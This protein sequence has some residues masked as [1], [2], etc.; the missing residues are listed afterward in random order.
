[1]TL[2]PQDAPDNASFAISLIH[3]ELRREG[4]ENYM[5]VGEQGTG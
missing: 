1:M 5:K 3:L 4:K 2:R